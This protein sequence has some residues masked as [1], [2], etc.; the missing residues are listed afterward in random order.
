[1]R[2]DLKDKSQT[3]ASI[4]DGVSGDWIYFPTLYNQKS[5]KINEISFQTLQAVNRCDPWQR[6]TNE[7]SP[8]TTL[9]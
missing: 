9:E 2:K 3:S 5:N 4:H 8:I 6:E 1:M 7:M